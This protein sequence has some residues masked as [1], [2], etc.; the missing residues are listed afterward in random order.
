MIKFSL[1]IVNPTKWIDLPGKN[2]DYFF[3]K[4]LSTNKSFEIQLTK[5]KAHNIL[6]VEINTFLNGT[7]HAGPEIVIEIFGIFFTMKLYDH[8]HW[9]Y[10]NS[11]WE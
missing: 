9:D 4:T 8:R 3:N 10:I 11:K 5:F 1:F 7:D 6:C 2:F